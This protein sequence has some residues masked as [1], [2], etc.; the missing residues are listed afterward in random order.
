[1]PLLHKPTFER[2]LRKGLHYS[3][4]GFASV[5]LLVCAIGSRYHDDPRVCIMGDRRS[6][7]WQYFDQVQNSY[8]SLVAAPKLY[9]IQVFAVGQVLVIYSIAN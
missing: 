2:A 3:D 8:T 7:G 5:V 9:D 4:S 6:A 1:M